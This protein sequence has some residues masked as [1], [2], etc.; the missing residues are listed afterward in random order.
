VNHIALEKL[1]LKGVKEYTKN[2]K[3]E[4]EFIT[5]LGKHIK[6]IYELYDLFLNINDNEFQHHV[7]NEKNDFR[8]WIYFVIKDKKLASD[9]KPIKNKNEML[10]CIEKRV[11]EYKSVIENSNNTLIKKTNNN[12]NN[13]K[14][15]KNS[16]KKDKIKKNNISKNNKINKEIPNKTK[17]INKNKSITDKLLIKEMDDYYK[18]RLKEEK[19]SM[20]ILGIVIGI[21]IGLLIYRLLY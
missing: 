4:E 21:M 12:N 3:E 16:S 10:K 1:D 6:N 9:I 13:T 11:N 18:K 14:Q 17:N 8:N 19:K 7:N 2:S 15:K 20:I 5:L